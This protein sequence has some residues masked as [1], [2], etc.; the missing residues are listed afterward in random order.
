MWC[1][2]K[3]YRSRETFTN[4]KFTI[5][6]EKQ[7]YHMCEKLWGGGGGVWAGSIP[8]SVAEQMWWHP[9]NLRVQ[10]QSLRCGSAWS[11]SLTVKIQQELEILSCPLLFLEEFSTT[12]LICDRLC[13]LVVRVPGYRSRGP[14]SIPGANRFSEKWWVW[15]GVHPVSWV[16][17]RSY[18][19]EKVT[20][21]VQKYENTA[22]GICHADHVV[23]SIRKSWHELR[24]QAAAAW[25]VY[26]ARRLR[27]RSLFVYTDF[28]GF[29]EESG[30]KLAHSTQIPLMPFI[31]DRDFT[32]QV[33]FNFLWEF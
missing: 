13:G 18:L 25:S 12:I 5:S 21:P 28:M 3:G 9:C 27:L 26:F 6:V 31:G 24:R 10:A 16:Q 17:L 22:V 32:F 11:S 19:K 7:Y 29:I 8:S 33:Y 2:C 1:R 20:A 4:T 23:P 30:V 15:N 14:G